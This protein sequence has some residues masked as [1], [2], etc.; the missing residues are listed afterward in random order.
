[1]V[2]AL[3]VAVAI[4]NAITF[5]LFGVDKLQA[6]RG[7]RRI[8]ERTLLTWLFLSG[9]AGAWFA[10]SLFRHKTVKAPFRR[11]A[12]LWTVL[13]PVWLLAWWTVVPAGA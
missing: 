1:M 11:F 3:W 4:A 5:L 2:P 7:G 12:I 6:R 9:V 13:N 10:M 8:R